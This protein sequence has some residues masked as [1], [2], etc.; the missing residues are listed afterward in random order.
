MSE[1]ILRPYQD[2]A[3]DELR[4]G[5]L[6]GFLRQMLIAAT[7]AGKTIIFSYLAK[8]SVENKKTVLILTDRK[9]L[10]RQAAKS[11][12]GF[13]VDV[14]LLDA[15]HKPFSLDAQVYCAMS[16]TLARRLKIPKY[17]EYLKN[18]DVVI[19][20]EAHKTEFEKF[21]EY[22]GEKTVVIG[23]TATPIRTGNQPSLELTYNAI[24]EVL[25]VRELIDQG[26]LVPA[27]SF[28][29]PVDLAE[30]KMKGAD[31]EQG[32]LNDFYDDKD[33]YTGAVENYLKHAPGTK[34]LLFCSGVKNSLAIRDQFRKA[35][36]SAEHLDSE[37]VTDKE[38]ENILERFER[39]EFLVLCNVGI[40]T[41]GYD[42]PSIQTIILYRATKSLAL[43]LQMCGR[44]SR[45]F[46]G[47]DHFKILD[48]GN[49]FVTHGLWEQDREW[50]LKKLK[51]TRKT[52][53]AVPIK[54]CP[55]CEAILPSVAHACRFCDYVFPV[56]VKKT[57]QVMLEEL[58]FDEENKE[59]DM[60]GWFRHLERRTEIMSKNHHFTIRQLRTEKELIEY[61]NYKK[62]DQVGSWVRGVL[63]RR[64]I[65]G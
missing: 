59:K 9:E 39:G 21:F 4:E 8:K 48:F 26:Y 6:I 18:V 65:Y 28:A 12:S 27:R 17:V 51:K 62:Y 22:F 36:I 30:V 29:V 60:F 64:K 20:D 19:I 49:N 55:S 1:I 24:V 63:Q 45:L 14:N 40:L 31:Y 54:E 3:V 57:V 35:G 33:L 53:G 42:C 44:G 5:I 34:T 13:G 46:D 23:A 11:I 47:K 15:D 7:G 10:I 37:N 52:K 50:S 58:E 41:T 16:Q 32:S 43:F 61:A 2:D 38:R 56:K 25:S